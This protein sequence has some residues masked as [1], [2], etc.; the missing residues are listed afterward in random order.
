MRFKKYEELL[1]A[2]YKSGLN[3]NE[4]HENSYYGFHKH[5]LT[6]IPNLN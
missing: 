5:F 2:S 4:K 6:F 1:V 3:V